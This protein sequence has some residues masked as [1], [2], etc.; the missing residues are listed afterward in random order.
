MDVL[1]SKHIITKL[2]ADSGFDIMAKGNQHLYL[3]FMRNVRT[4][5]EMLVAYPKVSV[6]M[7]GT[8]WFVI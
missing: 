2:S 8:L 4:A 6:D 7:C 1:I 3:K 5:K